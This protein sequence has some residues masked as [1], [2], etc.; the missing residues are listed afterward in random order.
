MRGHLRKRLLI[1]VPVVFGVVTLVF[2]LIHLMPGDP[3]DVMLGESAR[4]A[5]RTE[6]R[7]RL[8][9][10]RPLTAQYFTF[11][12]G[13]ASGNLGRSLRDD[14]SVARLLGDRLPATLALAAAA[15]AISLAIAIPLGLLAALRPNGPFDRISLAGSL[16][17]V[18]TPNFWLGPM[19]VMLFAVR[20]GWLPVSGRGGLD[21]LLLPALTLGASAAGILTRIT[22]ASV[23]EVLHEDWARTALAKGA[24]RSRLLFCHALPGALTPILSVTGLELGGLLAGSIIT[25]TIFAWPGIGRLTVEAIASRDYPVV[26]GCVLVIALAYVLVNLLTDLA[27]TWADPRIRYGGTERS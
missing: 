6:L 23:I 12:A 1:A 3:V 15:L 19:L 17:A 26:Q 5:D 10:D 4:P 21:H 8:G 11:V 2:S 25:E 16:L 9:L 24:S 7:K 22:R 27:Y 13:L 20:L 18:A 14:R